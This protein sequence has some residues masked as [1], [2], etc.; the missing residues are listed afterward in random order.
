MPVPSNTQQT[1]QTNGRRESLA[2]VIYNISPTE[3][4]IMSNLGRSG[5]EA[6]LEEWQTDS[7][8]APDPNN[9]QI[10]GD[11]ATTLAASPTTRVAN[12]TQISTKTIRVSGRTEAVRKAGRKSEIA[13]QRAKRSKEIKRDMETIM[14]GTNQAATLGNAS[15]ASRLGSILS[16]LRTNVSLGGGSAANPAA[17]NPLP[18][19][20]RTD[21]TQ[22]AFTETLLKDVL[23]LCYIN[24][25]DPS[26]VVVGAFNKGVA[27]TFA[28]VATKTFYQ[29][30]VKET[31]I[32][33][34]ADVYVG[35]F[36]AV[37][38]VPD[39]F[40]RARDALVLDPSMAEVKFLREF[41]FT[42]LAKTGDSTQ[43]ML[44][45]E[46]TLKV[47]NEAAHGLIADL[48]TA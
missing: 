44:L 25:A 18:G 12:A 32:I 1:F 9:A 40:T 19:G 5:A 46:Y 14:F 7:L 28:G 8:A 31:A 22:R 10:E 30:A 2:D 47:N 26:M 3:T 39:R 43:E 38:F 21:G 48:T 27:S 36:H 11:D 41:G 15:T 23:Q 42:E 45:A 17:P 29:S 20:T 24:G 13:Y 4:P 34:A 35:D 37:S 6:A 16:W 33:G